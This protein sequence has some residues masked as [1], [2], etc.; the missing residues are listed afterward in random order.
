MYDPIL[1][2]LILHNLPPEL[3]KLYSYLPE[4][5]KQDI[6]TATSVKDLTRY[7]KPKR[8]E[9][10]N[11]EIV[12]HYKGCVS[13]TVEKYKARRK[14]NTGK[15][16]QDK[17]VKYIDE[18]QIGD[19]RYERNKF[20][21]LIPIGTTGIATEVKL[22]QKDLVLIDALIN[23]VT[24]T[25]RTCEH[26]LKLPQDMKRRTKC[27]RIISKKWRMKGDVKIKKK[28]LKQY[29]L[30]LI[31]NE[32]DD[33]LIATRTKMIDETLSRIRDTFDNIRDNR[34]RIQELMEERRNQQ[35]IMMR[36]FKI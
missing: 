13:T 32:Y 17:S 6:E 9:Y 22:M 27:W 26:Y 10:K 28:K 8:Y 16:R 36:T 1:K 11:K 19:L 3:Q 15:R 33:S 20:G 18:F 23:K 29:D 24:E 25:E 35:P 30:D 7:Q 14:S 31:E 12:T 34:K 21:L 2:R 5:S 4:W